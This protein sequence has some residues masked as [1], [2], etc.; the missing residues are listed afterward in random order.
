MEA[1]SS[2]RAL[3]SL[4]RL[5]KIWRHALALPDIHSTDNMRSLSGCV[6]NTDTLAVTA[7][8]LSTGPRARYFDPLGRPGHQSLERLDGN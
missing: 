8:A 3:L 6:G 1:S 5:R 7:F 4:C 2:D